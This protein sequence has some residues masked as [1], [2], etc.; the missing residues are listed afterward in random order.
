MNLG[1]RRLLRRLNI[2]PNTYY[3]YQKADYYTQK[4]QIQAQ[5]REIYHEHNVVDGY[6]SMTVY[7]ARKGFHY[8]PVSI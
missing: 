3:N 8:S 1:P 5:N 7:L 2:C 6:R 4:S